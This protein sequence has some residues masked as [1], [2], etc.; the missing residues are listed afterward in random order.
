M[1]ALEEPRRPASAVFTRVTSSAR[2]VTPETVP[3][4]KPMQPLWPEGAAG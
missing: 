2:L 4:L 1:S 3:A